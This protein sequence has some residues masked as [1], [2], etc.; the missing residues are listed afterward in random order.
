MVCNPL[1]P[2]LKAPSKE[3]SALLP[4]FAELPVQ[5]I[6]IPQAPAEFDAAYA[7]L[8]AARFLGFDTESKPLFNVG[9]HDSGP[10]LVQLATPQQAW[11]LQLHHPL[12]LELTREILGAAHICKVGFGLDN[13]RQSLP[14]RLGTELVN[15]E[16]LDRRFKQLGYG[17]SIGVRAAVA[18]VLRQNFRKSKRTTTSNWAS[19]QLTMAQC[20]YAAND[21]HAPAVIQTALQHWEERQPKPS[22]PSRLPRPGQR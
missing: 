13:D 6:H 5:A 11:L 9:Q 7:A 17:P 21:A 10:H 12:A 15:V 8:T 14:R 16:D 2:K 18:L 4:P 1:M 19:P 3:D 20:R 22:A